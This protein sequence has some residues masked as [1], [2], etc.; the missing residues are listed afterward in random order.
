VEFF[1][2]LLIFF[3]S[4]QVPAIILLY[5]IHLQY[6]E[7][8]FTAEYDFTAMSVEHQYLSG[9]LNILSS[10]RSYQVLCRVTL[11]LAAEAVT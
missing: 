11:L 9:L 10:Q 4:N 2:A 5:V 6:L 3:L 1:T 8:R 7:I